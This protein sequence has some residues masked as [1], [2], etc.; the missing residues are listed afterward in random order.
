MSNLIV[1]DS[2][3]VD[4][5]GVQKLMTLRAIPKSARVD[6][7]RHIL[8][9]VSV[10]EAVEALGHEM[11]VDAKTLDQ[12]AHFGNV[13]GPAGVKSRFTHPGMSSDGMGRFLGRMKSFRKEGDRVLADLYLSDSAAE[14]P[15]GDLREYVERLAA[16]DPDAAG[17]SIV[18]YMDTAWV[19]EN[20]E[21]AEVEIEGSRYDRPDNATTEL[22]FARLKVK[23]LRSGEQVNPL[24]AVDLVDEPAANRQGMF[25]VGTSALAE[26]AFAELDRR[27]TARQGGITLMSEAIAFAEDQGIDDPEKVSTFLRAWQAWRQAHP[28]TINFSASGAAQNTKEMKTNEQDGAQSAAPN[29]PAFSLPEEAR[30]AEIAAAVSEALAARDEAD[31]LAKVA[32]KERVKAITSLGKEHGLT[33]EAN[34]AITEETPL[35][36]FKDTVI[37][38][39]ASR[40]GEAEKKI[41]KLDA[42]SGKEPA[43]GA[44]LSTIEEQ[45]EFDAK[46]DALNAAKDSSERFRLMKEI[47]ALREAAKN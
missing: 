40:A 12:V 37:Q 35:E 18:A 22:P 24:R 20:D 1:F 33:E 16:N 26:Q 11:I 13:N 6:T 9:G 10:I 41:A 3:G 34:E 39:L 38:S 15:E 28:I 7:Q 8:A 14:S 46:L 19:V 21:G 29:A 27:G 44:L 32:E 47:K 31:K 2:A 36:E 5:T 45:S 25:S 4:G 23:E 42:N 30:Q 17:M 43:R